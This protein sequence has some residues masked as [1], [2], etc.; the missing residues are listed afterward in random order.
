VGFLAKQQPET[1]SDNF[2]VVALKTKQ[3]GRKKAKTFKKQCKPFHNKPSNISLV[4][5]VSDTASGKLF[6]TAQNEFHAK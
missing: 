3:K 2:N 5:F 1:Q 6:H 4:L